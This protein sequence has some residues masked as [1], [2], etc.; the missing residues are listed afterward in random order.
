MDDFLGGCLAILLIVGAIVVCVGFILI[1]YWPFLLLFGLLVIMAMIVMIFHRQIAEAV[2]AAF[3]GAKQGS[4]HMIGWAANELSDQ[5][6][7]NYGGSYGMGNAQ[8]Q[9]WNE[10]AISQ[11][12]TR[13]QDQ[14]IEVKGYIDSLRQQFIWGQKEKIAIA[15]NRFLDIEI[16]RLQRLKTYRQHQSDIVLQPHQLENRLLEEQRRKQALQ[17]QIENDDAEREIQGLDNEYRKI[18]KQFGVE[19]YKKKI[20]DLNYVPPPPPR[21]MTREEI[22][23]KKRADLQKRRDEVRAEIVA[24]RDSDQ[25]EQVDEGLIRAKM[26]QLERKLFDIEQELTDLI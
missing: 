1:N 22:L 20:A 21:E 12:L 13:L 11:E 5:P 10:Q 26:N 24:V 9:V 8:L 16:E 25:Y 19:E 23:A 4:E 18:E 17:R 7:R 15:R 6:H 2:T 3:D 14:P